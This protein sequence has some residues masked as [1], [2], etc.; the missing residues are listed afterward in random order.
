MRVTNYQNQQHHVAEM[1]RGQER[2]EE[3]RNRVSSGLRIETPSD[4]PDQIAEL[5]RTQSHAAE[6][7][8]RGSA[9]DAALVTMKAGE[10][11]LGDITSALRQAKTLALQAR[12]AATSDDQRQLI[13]DQ[14][15]QIAAHVR[16][17]ANTQASDRYL[18]A[19]TATDTA[20]FT[21]GPPVTYT[22]N[23]GPTLLS[24]GDSSTLP[25]NVN[26][27]ELLNASGGTDL[28]QN[29]DA[30]ATAIRSGDDNGMAT[31]MGR[32][33]Q[34]VDNSIRLR[35]DIGAR[36]QYVTMVQNRDQND[37]LAT[38]ERQSQLQDADTA[39]AILDYQS[40]EYA[41][42]AGLAVVSRLNQPSLLD[43]LR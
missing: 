43:Y 33:D 20:P 21:A 40:A 42:E 2:L 35:G 6:L 27:E 17:L 1:L 22:G 15:Q 39:S 4:A 7:T 11:T 16:D 32:L 26:G 3:A 25:T 28:F 41:H 5:M 24:V 34:D 30:L 38:Q 18:F 23:D 10:S 31:G 8:R 13:A 37:L 29:L 9:A 12:N 36:I 14:I 19:G